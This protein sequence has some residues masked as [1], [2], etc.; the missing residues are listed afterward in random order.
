MMLSFEMANLYPASTG[1]PMTVWVSPRDGARH[2]ALVRVS[3]VYGRSM[4]IGNAAVVRIRPS[5]H[6][7]HGHLT[8]A[9]RSVVENWIR[10][11]ETALLD[12]WD[13]KID[14]AQLATRLVKV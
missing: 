4:D 11:N 3:A 7:I 5:P 1:L 12:H 10:R 14:A 13:G 2:D 6:V 8:P 9:D